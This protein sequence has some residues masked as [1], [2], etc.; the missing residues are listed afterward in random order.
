MKPILPGLVVALILGCGGKKTPPAT[1]GDPVAGTPSSSESGASGGSS[2]GGAETPAVSESDSLKSKVDGLVTVIQTGDA[3]ALR[4]AIAELSSLGSRNP[5]L[6]QIPYNQ[7][8]AWMK[9]GDLANA[10]KSF[11]SATDLDP[12]LGP[13]WVNLGAIAEREGDLSRALRNYQTGLTHAPDDPDLVVGV[14]SVLRKQ[15]RYDDAIREAKAALLKNANNLNAYNNLG[16]VYIDQGNLDL[17][18]F[19][20]L[21][22]LDFVVGADKNAL[23]Q[24]NLGRVYLLR[25]DKINARAKLELALS[26]DPKLVVALLFLA[27]DRL[28]NRDW[29]AAEKMLTQARELE[30]ENP[31]IWMNLGIAYRGLGRFEEAKA[32][33]E[34]ALELDPS[35][36][37]PYLNLAL[38]LG[39]H[40]KSYDEAL[41]SVQR[42]RDAGGKDLALAAAWQTDLESQK[43]KYEIALERERRRK[44]RERKQEEQKRLAEEHER[45]V[46]TWEQEE[47]NKPAPA[48]DGTAPAPDGGTTPPSPDGA[49]PWSGTGSEGAGSDPGGAA[50][51]TDG[52][53]AP[54]SGTP[55]SG[56]ESPTSPSEPAPQDGASPWG[57]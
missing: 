53:P 33:Y 25:G 40:M 36:A 57:G 13:A 15:K 26:L 24:A 51:G 35:N 3:A 21:R 20:Y 52:S 39:E 11:M 37:D 54:G 30:P 32:A 19:I 44:E 28:E 29:T 16:L 48:P 7:G 10:R 49:S 12:S 8:V 34:K 1:A 22:A 6:A 42:Y 47:K 18:L 43:Q 50:P 46:Q 38:L 23:I 31:G 5:T 27:D 4:A 9:L 41:A 55:E 2:E 56:Q 14:I 17:A 45:N